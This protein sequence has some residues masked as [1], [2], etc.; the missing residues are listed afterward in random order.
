MFT[1]ASERREMMGRRNGGDEPEAG[2]EGGVREEEE[3]KERT[4][5]RAVRILLLGRG[6]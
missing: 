6:T 4:L 2:D 1:V 5:H 3:G